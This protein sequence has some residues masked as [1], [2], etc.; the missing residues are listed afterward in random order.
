L[1]LTCVCSV[2]CWLCRWLDLRTPALLMRYSIALDHRRT[3]P[4]GTPVPHSRHAA[5]NPSA[6]G[7]WDRRPVIHSSRKFPSADRR[8]GSRSEFRRLRYCSTSRAVCGRYSYL[9]TASQP[10]PHAPPSTPHPTAPSTQHPQHPHAPHSM[11]STQLQEVF[12]C[13]P[14]APKSAYS[15]VTQS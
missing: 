10:H 5:L 9:S 13:S 11:H 12:R 3:I 4:Y 8:A 2:V 1:L 14:S 7:F 15:P 6:E